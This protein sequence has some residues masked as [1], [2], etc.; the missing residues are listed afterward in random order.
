LTV[1]VV[2][3]VA[4]SMVV[5]VDGVV[6]SMVAAADGNLLKQRRNLWRSLL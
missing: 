3:G 6:R 5:V 2:D 1:V 4:R